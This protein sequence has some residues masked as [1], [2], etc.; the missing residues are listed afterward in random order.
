MVIL[1]YSDAV[2]IVLHDEF[3]FSHTIVILILQFPSYHPCK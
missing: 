2:C 3:I 1:E